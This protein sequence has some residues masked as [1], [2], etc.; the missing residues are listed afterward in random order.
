[1]LSGAKEWLNPMLFLV[2]SEIIDIIDET[3]RKLKHPPPCLQAFL[4]DLPGN[5]FNAI[6][7]HLLRCFCERVEIEKGKNK[8][9]VTD[10]AGSFYGRLFPPNSLHFVHSSYAIM[11]ISKLS[12]EEIKSMME[13]EGSFKLQNMEVFNMDWDDYIKKADTKQVLDKTRRATMIANDIK[14]V[15]ESSLDNHLGED[16]IDD[17]FRRFKEDVFDYMETHKCQYVNIVILLTK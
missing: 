9:F 14:A 13:A 3:C 16:I 10:V 1:M 7:K 4:N 2:V 15:G 6:F 5:D 8:C 12:K 11:W 17:L